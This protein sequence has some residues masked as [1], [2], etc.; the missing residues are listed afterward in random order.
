M[1][2]KLYLCP[3]P[4]G[5]LGDISQRT[6]ETLQAA[7]L[8][9][10]EDTRNTGL[11]LSHYGIRVPL[12]SYHQHNEKQR[13]EELIQKMQQGLQIALVTDAGMP[14]ISDPG[15]ILV[16]RC[17]EA[18]IAVTALPGPCA[19]VTALA[20]SGLNSRRFVFEGFLP[21]VKKERQQV[22]E[23]L[24]T[25]NRT[26]IFY[27][28]PHRLKETL[29]AMA[30]VAGNR[31]AATVRELTKKFEEVQLLPLKDL[32]AYYESHEPRGEFVVLI[33]G[34]TEQEQE[35]DRQK[36]YEELTLEEHMALYA[37]LPEKDAMKAVARDRGITKREVYAKLKK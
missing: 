33:E 8:I 13:C 37:N 10:A 9:A 36:Q 1:E 11:L 18:G 20:L 7:D 27:E 16:R 29:K 4:I 19:F 26:V 23:G 15:Q 35:E 22:L 17:H 28:A 6:L 31:P 14:A 5:N 12:V 32:A 30:E 3:T 21:T 24:R 2:G 25:E 34:R